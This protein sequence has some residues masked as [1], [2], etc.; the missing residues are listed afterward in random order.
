MFK[1]YSLQRAYIRHEKTFRFSDK[2]ISKR[3]RKVAE[4][5]IHKTLFLDYIAKYPYLDTRALSKL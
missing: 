1:V 5:T 2:Y 3:T 4:K